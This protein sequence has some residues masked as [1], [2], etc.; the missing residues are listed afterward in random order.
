MFTAHKYMYK[1][2]KVDLI[3]INDNYGVVFANSCNLIFHEFNAPWQKQ[4]KTI[5]ENDKK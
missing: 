5:S 3:P 1:N 4:R 2:M